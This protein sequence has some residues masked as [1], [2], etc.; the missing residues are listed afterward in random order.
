MSDCV[1][2]Y[3]RQSRQIT[4][5]KWNLAAAALEGNAYHQVRESQSIAPRGVKRL[6]NALKQGISNLLSCT[7]DSVVGALDLPL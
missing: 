1:R 2:A 7:A 3:N 6:E 4:D 5:M